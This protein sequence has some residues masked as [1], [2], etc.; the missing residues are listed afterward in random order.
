MSQADLI[1]FIQNRY[2]IGNDTKVLL[3]SD[4]FGNPEIKTSINIE[5]R[6]SLLRL[7]GMAKRLVRQELQVLQNNISKIPASMSTNGGFAPQFVEPDMA[8][9][10]LLSNVSFYGPWIS[11][12][13]TGKTEVEYNADLVPWNF[14]GFEVLNKIANAKVNEISGNLTWSETGSIEIPG[15][16]ITSLG[17]Q[18]VS[19][20]PYVSDI[21]VSIGTDGFITTYKMQSW[22]PRFNKISNTMTD[23][24]ARITKTAQVQSRAA[25][26][27][28]RIQ[29]RSK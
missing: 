4:S 11:S 19:G 18:L 20:G 8:A 28:F 6:K 9:I 5:K 17:Q 25:V 7:K 22:T 14:N 2:S 3:T 1:T 21:S 16:P 10:P 26:E 24:L 23:K 27:K 29:K 12:V 15:I 13:G